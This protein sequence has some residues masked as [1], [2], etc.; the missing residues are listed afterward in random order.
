MTDEE[1][2]AIMCQTVEE[3]AALK[4]RRTCLRAKGDNYRALLQA[5]IR[6]VA[7]DGQ[8]TLQASDWPSLEDIEAVR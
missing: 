7:G 8:G 1:M 6:V 2:R 4:K 5:A 3:L